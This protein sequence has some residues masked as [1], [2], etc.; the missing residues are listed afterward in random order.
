MSAQPTPAQ[1]AAAGLIAV[2]TYEEIEAAYANGQGPLRS[3]N[4]AHEDFPPVQQGYMSKPK[5]PSTT[6][7]TLGI[8]GSTDAASL[9]QM[10]SLGVKLVRVQ[11]TWNYYDEWDAMN[12]APFY[13]TDGSFNASIAEQAN[14]IKTLCA[15][16]GI[17]VLF[18]IDGF[19]SSVA[20]PAGAGNYT[21]PF[22]Y[23]PA[24][25]AEACAWV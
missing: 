9:A 14:A 10:Q 22:P 8:N 5:A 11:V 19:I 6:F 25:Y 16:Y 13:N 1:L 23:T 4:A 17:T 15:S 7:P 18:L 2:T 3:Y 12:G 21:A 24:A 20:P